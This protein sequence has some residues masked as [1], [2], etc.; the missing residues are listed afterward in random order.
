MNF[1]KNILLI[2]LSILIIS[3]LLFYL[4]GRITNLSYK[5]LGGFEI[6]LFPCLFII[7]SAIIIRIFPKIKAYYIIPLCWVLLGVFII[8]P[9]PIYGVELLYLINGGVAYFT[10]IL[11]YLV[12]T[13]LHINNIFEVCIVQILIVCIYHFTILKFS[14]FL[15]LKYIS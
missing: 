3:N 13:K 1:Y 11:E 4:V 6:I 12:N 14:Y 5:D 7:F 10:V 15:K 2:Y 8:F 9:R